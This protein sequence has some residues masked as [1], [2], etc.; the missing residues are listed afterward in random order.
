MIAFGSELRQ[1]DVEVHLRLS[2]WRDHGHH[3]DPAY[4]SVILHVTLEGE[5]AQPCRRQDG[6]A[7]PTLVL[8]PALR[9]PIARLPPDPA[10]PPLGA[11]AD[12][13]CV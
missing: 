3:L 10:L 12:T 11:I 9:G 8:A 5:P 6:T 1:G 13:P 7:V 2:G 4:N